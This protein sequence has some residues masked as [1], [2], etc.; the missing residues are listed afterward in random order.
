MQLHTNTH[1]ST[2]ENELWLRSVITVWKVLQLEVLDGWHLDSAVE[3]EAIGRPA[4]F[5]A[6]VLHVDHV[7]TPAQGQVA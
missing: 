1:L 4:H 5:W 6:L 3:V 2:L 7:S